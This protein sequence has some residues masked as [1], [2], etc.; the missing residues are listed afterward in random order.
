MSHPWTCSCGYMKDIDYRTSCTNVIQLKRR[1]TNA[2]RTISGEVL[3][4][5]LEKL[6][7]ALERNYKR[8]REYREPVGIGK[9]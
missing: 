3:R 7:R 9:I 1:T 2:A 8:R 5:C 4:K 6:E